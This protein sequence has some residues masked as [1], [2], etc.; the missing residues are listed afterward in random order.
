MGALV[1]IGEVGIH[2]AGGSLILRPSLLAMS[3]LGEPKEIV[4]TLSVVF[5]EGINCKPGARQLRGWKL[6]H[7]N[8]LRAALQVW[9]AC[10]PEDADLDWITGWFS[11]RGGWNMGRTDPADVILI[12]QSLLRHGVLGDPEPRDESEP[13]RDEDFSPGFDCRHHA[14][15][16]MGHLSLSEAQAWDMTMTG[17]RVALE[18]KYPKPA[19]TAAQ[20]SAARA[21]TEAE[22]HETMAWHDKVLA[23]NRAATG[24]L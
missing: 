23:A 14:A 8:Q 19:A 20:Q 7:Q 10:A 3:R 6:A 1:H 21:P 4:S 15:L 16:A 9:H 17:L 18:A 13:E 12:A 11:I 24:D 2:H 22:Y 5:G